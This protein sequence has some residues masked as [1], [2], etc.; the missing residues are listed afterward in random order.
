MATW[1]ESKPADS[2]Q[3]SQGAGEIRQL[4]VD[5]RERMDNEHVWSATGDNTDGKHLEGSA[6]ITTDT[7]APTNVDD[8]RLFYDTANKLLK[9]ANGSA[10]NN[11][12]VDATQVLNILGYKFAS[13][14][15]P[16]AVTATYANFV[17]TTINKKEASSILVVLG[18]LT[19]ITG[20][21]TSHECV[22][23]V[24]GSSVYDSYAVTSTLSN[25]SDRMPATIFTV[26]TGAA[27]GSHTVGLQVRYKAG[28]ANP[29]YVEFGSLL[30]LELRN[31]FTL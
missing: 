11:M 4:K 9:V 8:G 2:D 28:T 27:A 23:A 6:R 5:I 18:K 20:G 25:Y 15:G 7:V 13:A 3:I 16:Q 22:L 26:V 17:S 29:G 21:S 1:N 24:D 12:D 10:F 30:V 14:A 19:T 31:P